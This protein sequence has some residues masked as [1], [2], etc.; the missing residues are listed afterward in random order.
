MSS[1]QQL[2]PQL[3]DSAERIQARDHGS[4]FARMPDDEVHPV[5]RP[6]AGPEGS[7]DESL[8]H[9]LILLW[10]GLALLFATFFVAHWITLVAGAALILGGGVWQLVRHRPI[11]LYRGVGTI[12]KPAGS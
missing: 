8:N 11:R 6:G 5:T 3:T 12:K 4:A 7:L 1:E 9:P 10:V 2:P